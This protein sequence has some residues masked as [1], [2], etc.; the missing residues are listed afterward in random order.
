MAAFGHTFPFYPGPK[1]TFPMDTTLAI[2]VIIFLT[3]L[4]TF[5]IILPGI[6]GKMRLFWLLRVVT[7]LFI[8][9]AILAVNFSTE[10][11]VGQ[12]ST[13]T[14]YKAFSSQWI[15]ADV[16]LQVGLRGVNVM[17]TGTP[18]Q[19]LNETISYNEEFTWHLGKNYAEEYARALEKGLPD[20]VLYLAEKFTP[21]SPC[22]L[23]GQYRL[24]GHYTSAILWV[25]FLCWLLANVMLSMP[26][27]VY[28]GHML[29]ATGTFQLLGLLFFSMATSLA[30]P[31]PLHLGTAILHIHHGPA[32]WITLTTGL[33][34]VLLGLVMAVAYRMQPHRL[35]A[36][37]NQSVGENPGLEW[38]PE[39]G[40]LLS[41][42]YRTTAESPVPQDIP[43]SEASSKACIKEEHLR[44]PDCAL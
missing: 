1:P 7:S 32:F 9:A 20:P 18:V 27:L 26:V 24:A 16:G 33:L 43:L 44:V 12:A 30:P 25:A 8:G 13:N 28:G 23:H 5:I 21:T 3:A 39:E 6:R 42:H 17:L 31:C 40:G 4:V 19:Q 29:L 2:I 34:C 38:N 22:G 41:P 36:F 14:S 35:K 15:S 11:S 10:W 37:F